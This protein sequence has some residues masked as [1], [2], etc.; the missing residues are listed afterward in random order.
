MVDGPLIASA[1]LTPDYRLSI[2]VSGGRLKELTPADAL[3]GALEGCDGVLLTGG[4][5]V[6]P[7]EYGEPRRY[8][9]LDLDPARDACEIALARRA[10]AEHLPILAICRGA[11][12]L[13]VAAGGTLVQDIPR[14]RPGSLDHQR[15]EPKNALAH[16]VAVAPGTCLWTFLEPRLDARHTLQVNSRHHQSVKRPA[17]GFIASALAPDGIVEAIEKTDEPF[18]VGVQWHPENFHASGEFRELF[19]G[20]V[21]AARRY[22]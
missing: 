1:W 20:F 5:D 16:A 2:E 18:C 7:A 13:N 17:P 15:R 19:D 8:D 22:R 11:Q 10:L 3:P 4:P 21:A 9:N 12:V 6:D 14:D